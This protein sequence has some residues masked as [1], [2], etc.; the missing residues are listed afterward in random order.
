MFV[1]QRVY[2]CRYG[3]LVS[4]VTEL[5][6]LHEPSVLPLTAERAAHEPA[7]SAGEKQEERE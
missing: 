4:P 5:L 2:V 7:L 3:A 1:P 6:V